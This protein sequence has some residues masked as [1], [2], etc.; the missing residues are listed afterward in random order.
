M[1]CLSPSWRSRVPRRSLVDAPWSLVLLLRF[2]AYDRTPSGIAPAHRP[3]VR[4]RP[5]RRLKL[6]RRSWLDWTGLD[7]TGHL[8]NSSFKLSRIFLHRSSYGSVF[9]LV[10]L[11]GCFCQFNFF[12]SLPLHDINFM[13]LGS[14]GLYVATFLA[15]LQSGSKL[16][17]FMNS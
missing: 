12:R 9:C 6:C 14:W 16:Y 4:S 11:F 13:I 7:W 5:I 2:A 8:K 17:R 10:F 1:E 3:R 15:L